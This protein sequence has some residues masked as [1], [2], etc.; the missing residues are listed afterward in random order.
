MN[1]KGK[2]GQPIVENRKPSAALMEAKKRARQVNH[3]NVHL[4]DIYQNVS[5]LYCEFV[6]VSIQVLTLSFIANLPCV[7]R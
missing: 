4:Y 7:R 2:D 5:A 3:K 1:S 6:Y